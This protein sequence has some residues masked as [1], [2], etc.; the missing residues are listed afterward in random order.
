MLS[1]LVSH[2]V[3]K[4]IYQLH[5]VILT[6]CCSHLFP[7]SKVNGLNCAD[8]SLN[9]I[10]SSHEIKINLFIEVDGRLRKAE[11]IEQYLIAISARIKAWFQIWAGGNQTDL[12]RLEMIQI[13]APRVVTAAI[14]LDVTLNYSVMMFHGN[15]YNAGGKITVCTY[16]TRWLMACRSHI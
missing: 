2:L 7:T 3:V 6:K 10:H 8:V 9:N 4:Q 15:F 11:L 16:F 1:T 5:H 12:E 13:D 14:Q